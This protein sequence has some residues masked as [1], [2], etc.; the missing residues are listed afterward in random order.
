MKEKE[1]PFN[2]CTG[3]IPDLAEEIWDKNQKQ[4]F[5]GSESIAPVISLDFSKISFSDF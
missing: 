4:I 5:E 3:V 2:S 1:G